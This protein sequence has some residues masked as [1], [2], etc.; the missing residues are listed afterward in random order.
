MLAQ[1]HSFS[2]KKEMHIPGLDGAEWSWNSVKTIPKELS[3]FNL[4]G[5]SLQDPLKKLVFI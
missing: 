3:I 4:S 2:L 1:G 5:G